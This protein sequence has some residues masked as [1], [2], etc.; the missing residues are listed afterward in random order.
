MGRSELSTSVVKWSE[1]LRNR[2]SIIIRRYKDHMKFY[3]FVHIL[4]DLLC[5]IVRMVVCFVCFCLILCIMYCYGNVYVFLLLCTF[6]SRYC[7]SLCCSVYCLCVN[8]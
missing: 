6:R 8:V 3:C 1:D 4:L 2:L 7:V 5:K